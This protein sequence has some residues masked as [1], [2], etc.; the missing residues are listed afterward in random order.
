V[1]KPV[2]SVIVKPILILVVRVVHWANDC[3]RKMHCIAQKEKRLQCQSGRRWSSWPR[4]KVCQKVRLASRDWMSWY[5]H[6]VLQ[7]CPTFISL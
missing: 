3:W 5:V 2:L 7:K 4:F 1:E 6:H